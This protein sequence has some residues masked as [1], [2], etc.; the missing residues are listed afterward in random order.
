[1]ANTMDEKVKYAA[2]VLPDI[3]LLEYEI[4]FRLKPVQIGDELLCI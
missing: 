1:M 3:T 2:L 4:D